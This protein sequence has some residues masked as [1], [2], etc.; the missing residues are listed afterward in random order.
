MWEKY[1]KCEK[2]APCKM[3][4]SHLDNNLDF[5]IKNAMHIPIELC[6]VL[7]LK[8]VAPLDRSGQELCKALHKAHLQWEYRNIYIFR[9]FFIFE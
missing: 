7:L 2:N 9:A 6:S 1:E 8:M 5:S 3:S 4:M